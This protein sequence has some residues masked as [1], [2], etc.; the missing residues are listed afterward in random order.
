MLSIAH[1]QLTTPSGYETPTRGRSFHLTRPSKQSRSA[2]S[3]PRLQAGGVQRFGALSPVFTPSQET[4]LALVAASKAQRGARDF[5]T[6]PRGNR[7]ELM[8]SH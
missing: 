7:A 8:W 1:A 3:S 6:D 4:P 2:K 5:T